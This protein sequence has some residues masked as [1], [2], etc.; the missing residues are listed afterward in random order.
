MT[1]TFWVERKIPLSLLVMLCIQF[2]TVI[3]WATQ[4]DA[5]VT[6]V[7]QKTSGIESFNEK[8]ARIEERLVSVKQDVE[9]IKHGLERLTAGLLR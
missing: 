6:V 5:R 3:M 2:G 1:K 8:F 9:S 4:L 7:E